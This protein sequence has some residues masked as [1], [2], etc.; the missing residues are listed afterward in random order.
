MTLIVCRALLC[1]DVAMRVVACPDKFRGTAS[2]VEAASAIAEAAEAADHECVRV[3]MADGG[4][5]TLDVLGGANRTSVVTGPLGDRVEAEWRL[6]RGVAVI[7]MARASGLEL[8]GGADGNEPLEATT[9]GTGELI[10]EAV[11]AGARRV[12]VGVG[13]SATT[14]GGLGALKAMAPLGRYK[15]IE[16]EVACDVETAFVDAAT[17]FAPQKGASDVQAEM[18]RRRLSRLADVYVHEHGVD[19]SEVVGS[20]AA[21]G[22]AGGLLVAGATLGRGFDLIAEAAGLH[23]AIEQADLVITGEGRL[24]QSSFNGKVVG[25]VV[26]LATELEVSVVGVVGVSERGLRDRLHVVDLCERF[27]VEAAHSETLRCIGDATTELL[28]LT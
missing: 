15:G 19:V 23:E 25:G 18:L 28:C 14:D 7:E 13:G 27:G 20:G 9:F 21:G 10:A 22:L 16:I 26:S 8:A 2:A 3:P 12:I 5:G 4:E 11:A 6:S 1:D 17:E 24:D